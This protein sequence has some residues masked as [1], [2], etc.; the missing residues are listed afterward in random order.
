MTSTVVKEILQSLLQVFIKLLLL[1]GALA[2]VVVLGGTAI[3]ESGLHDWDLLIPF[4]GWFVIILLLIIAW[5]IWIIVTAISSFRRKKNVNG[6]FHV[7]LVAL[8]VLLFIANSPWRA[9]D[10]YDYEIST[11][12]A[13]E[14]S[15]TQ[16]D[17]LID[18]VP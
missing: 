8:I 9:E 11:Q 1:L 13:P 7:G 14:N 16:S 3:T 15:N 18:T 10:G 2:L 12:T 5:I 17:P 6:F 4:L